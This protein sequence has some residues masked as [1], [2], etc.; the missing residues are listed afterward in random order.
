MQDVQN[1]GVL[2]LPPNLTLRTASVPIG[3]L[4]ADL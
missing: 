4:L 3:Q 1:T 2:V